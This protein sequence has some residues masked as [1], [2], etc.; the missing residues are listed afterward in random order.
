MVMTKLII[1]TFKLFL[2]FIGAY[3]IHLS[4]ISS[5]HVWP[6]PISINDLFN[7]DRQ[8]FYRVTLPFGIGFLNILASSF[9]EEILKIAVR[10]YTDEEKR[11]NQSKSF[12][13]FLNNS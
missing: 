2:I 8:A 7:P 10:L 13:Q 1:L 9:F 4:G 6:Q 12:K 5:F 3:F 11:K